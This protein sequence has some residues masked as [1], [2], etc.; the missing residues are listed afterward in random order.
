MTY[1]Y[2]EAVRYFERALSLASS[3]SLTSPTWEATFF[4]LGHSFRKLRSVSFTTDVLCMLLVLIV[5]LDLGFHTG[6][7]R[8]QFSRMSAP[9]VCRRA[10]R[11]PFIR[12]SVSPS[13]S[14]EIWT[15][16]WSTITRH[17]DLIQGHF[18]VRFVVLCVSI[19]SFCFVLFRFV[20]PG[21]L[22]RRT[23]CS[24]PWTIWQHRPSQCHELSCRNCLGRDLNCR[25]DIN[26]RRKTCCPLWI[27]TPRIAPKVLHC[28]HPRGLSHTF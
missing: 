11:R 26:G 13:I 20:F 18:G 3:D 23:C 15:P 16:L 6:I 17:S 1:S 2:S 28:S 10:T 24:V 22:S 27:P 8:R 14:K 21:T 7:F 5:L 12:H 25:D 4:N 19:D 9:S